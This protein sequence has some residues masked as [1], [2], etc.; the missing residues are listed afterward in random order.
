MKLKTINI[1]RICRIVEIFCILMVLAVSLND[2]TLESF[3]EKKSYLLTI[4]FFFLTVSYIAHFVAVQKSSKP[5]SLRYGLWIMV[6]ICNII[7]SI[8]LKDSDQLLPVLFYVYIT[9]LLVTRIVLTFKHLRL[10]HILL[11]LFCIGFLAELIAI[12]MKLSFADD[13]P[14]SNVA[15]LWMIGVVVSIH[16]LLRVVFLSF[17]RIRLDI[18]YKIASRSMALEILSGLLI[19]IIAFSFVLRTIEPQM[20][21]LS[22]ALWYCFALVTTIGFGDITVTTVVGRILSVILGI[23]GIVVVALITSIIVNFYTELK[24]E[25]EK[26]LQASAN[27]P[28]EPEEKQ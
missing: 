24:N 13:Q 18:L 16:M 6:G 28:T 25:R 21:S 9:P 20:R 5:D 1:S 19:L 2:M 8:I 12:M 3:S 27:K 11:N 22:D 15:M 26:A 14:E 4:G 7:L 23:Y 10:K 17:H